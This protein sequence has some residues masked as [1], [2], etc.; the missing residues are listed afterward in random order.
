MR[1]SIPSPSSRSR[2]S[3]IS[4]YTFSS[5]KPTDYFQSPTSQRDNSLIANDDDVVPYPSEHQLDFLFSPR[6]E[7]GE[8]SSVQETVERRRKEKKRD[9]GKS[10]NDKKRLSFMSFHSTHSTHS[11]HSSHSTHSTHSIHSSN[12]LNSS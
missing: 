10:R 1:T 2:H 3:V 11:S 12:T 6:N 9:L 8:T 5:P 4:S 7:E